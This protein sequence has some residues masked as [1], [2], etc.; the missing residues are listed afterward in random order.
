[1][2]HFSAGFGV[3]I[4]VGFAVAALLSLGG[5]LVQLG[6]VIEFLVCILVVGLC[7]LA[8]VEMIRWVTRPKVIHI[9]EHGAYHMHQ[10]KPVPLKPLSLVNNGISYLLPPN[11]TEPDD[12]EYKED[13]TIP[14]YE[15]ATL[16]TVE[17]NQEEDIALELWN[18]GYNSRAKLSQQMGV[19]PHR[20]TQLIAALKSKG[21]LTK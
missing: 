18:D 2:K 10:G 12:E 11:P 16:S 8:V 7:I 9:G 19:T 14:T 17:T 5:K 4:A 15:K 3:G 21:R 1:M 20:A 6:Y 13:E